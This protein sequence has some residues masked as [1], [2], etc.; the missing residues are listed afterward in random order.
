MLSR[1]VQ[2]IDA[3]FIATD[4]SVTLLDSVSK[5]KSVWDKVVAAGFKDE[6]SH[7]DNPMT[8]ADEIM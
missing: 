1:L 6:A 4:L 5:L 3:G 8:V 2:L 7:S